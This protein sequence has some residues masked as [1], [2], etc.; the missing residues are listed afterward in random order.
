MEKMRRRNELCLIA[1]KIRDNWEKF[2]AE[3]RKQRKRAS[4]MKENNCKFFFYYIL[5]TEVMSENHNLIF[6]QNLLYKK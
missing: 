3:R 1:E 2:A 5:S 4:E 6:R